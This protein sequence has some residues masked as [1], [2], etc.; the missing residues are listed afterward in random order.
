MLG[1]R[2]RRM[3]AGDADTDTPL[4]PADASALLLTATPCAQRWRQL[5]ASTALG[6]DPLLPLGWEQRSVNGRVFYIDHNHRTTSWSD[7]RESGAHAADDSPPEASAWLPLFDSEWGVGRA[8]GGEGKDGGRAPCEEDPS[9]SAAAAGAEA[10]PAPPLELQALRS[11]ALPPSSERLGRRA[12]LQL[13]VAREALL[14]G[15][16]RSHAERRRGYELLLHRR[17]RLLQAL[18]AAR[19]ER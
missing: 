10:L 15:R 2:K 1:F 9:P 8:G 11:G 5:H 3:H 16:S 13:A 7:P 17:C 4:T 18:H 12:H 14:E 6:P 19:R